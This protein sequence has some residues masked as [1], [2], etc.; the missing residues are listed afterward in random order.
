MWR[1]L[2]GTMGV[3][4]LVQGLNAAATTGF[5]PRTV[6]SEV[7]RRNRLATAPPANNS[8]WRQRGSNPW[9][10]ACKASALHWAISPCIS[11]ALNEHY[12]KF[13]ALNR[14]LNAKK[15]QG[16]LKVKALLNPNSTS[17]KLSALVY[18]FRKE[19]ERYK[20]G[21]VRRE[22]CL[23]ES[24]AEWTRSLPLSRVRWSAVT[25]CKKFL[26]SFF[27]SWF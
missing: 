15:K 6:W 20:A 26:L 11:G 13:W 7:R 17:T 27:F 9:P 21:P 10:L 19:F 4:S 12:L 22:P 3:K 1:L 24:S 16:T 8:A 2:L 23:V 25:G 18:N 14:A 5:E